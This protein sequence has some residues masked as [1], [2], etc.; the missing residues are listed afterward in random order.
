M[1]TAQFDAFLFDFDGTIFDTHASLVGTYRRGFEAIGL[2]CTPEDVAR[3]M[4]YALVQTCAHYNLSEEESNTLIQTIRANTDN[5]EFLALVK[6]FPETVEVIRSLKEKGKR[7][8][9]MSGNGE[10]HIRG[11]LQKFGVESLFEFVVGRSP[12]RRPK[13]SGDPVEAAMAYWPDINRDKVVYVGDSLQ[14]P[15]TAH[16]GG[17]HAILIDRKGEFPAYEGE[18]ITDLRELLAN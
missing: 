9:I 13:P 11:L 7:V 8:A 5:P 17:I 12:D 15:E 10:P 3:E 18:K 1:K 16:N 4:H 14:D 6:I 2:P